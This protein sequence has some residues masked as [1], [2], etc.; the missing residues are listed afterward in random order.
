MKKFATL[1]L[2]M[3]L[4]T[5]TLATGCKKDNQ[6]T[7]EKDTLIVGSYSEP[8]ALDPPNQ[9]MVPAGLVNVQLYE[10]LIRLNNVT[11]ELEP[12]LAESWEYI[13]ECTV[14]FHLRKDVYFHDGTKMTAEDVK[15]TFDRGPKCPPKSDDFEY[16]DPSKTKVIDENTF[17]LGTK[18]PFAAMLTYLTNNSTLIVCKHALEAKGQEYYARHPIG[19]GAYK[20]VEWIAGDRIVLERNEEYWGEKP[21]FKNLII[22]T[23]ADDTTRAMSLETGEIDVAIHLAPAQIKMLKNSEK[24]SLE[25]SPSYVTQCCKLNEDYEPLRDKRVRQ[26][27]HYAID[28]ETA[29]K[30]AYEIG[31]VADGPVPPSISVYKEASAETTYKQN[32]EKA[33]KLLKEAGYENG[34]ELELICNESQPRKTLAEMFANAW[35]KIGVTTHVR[36]MEFSAQL[37]KMDRGEWQAALL[38]FVAGGN[39]GEFYAWC[40]EAGQSDAETIHYNNP[41]INELFKLARKELDPAKSKEYYEEMQDIIRD[42]V[43]WLFIWFPDEIYGIGKGLTGIDLDPEGYTEFRF[44]KTKQP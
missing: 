39:N 42:E 20:F 34:F 21:E 6:P 35:G 26:A 25:I 38:G 8:T 22:R 12:C 23:I 1:L 3:L 37:A 44:I 16:F 41:R 4:A 24:V 29:G 32:I 7:Q 15:Y 40:F 30:I 14:R 11:G 28:M 36:V 9:D 5:A 18:T 31:R 2:A 33:K 43:P 27:L 10:G 17:E 13:D 19:T